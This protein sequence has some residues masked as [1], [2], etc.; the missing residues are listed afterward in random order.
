MPNATISLPQT[1][2]LASL[3]KFVLELDYYSEHN[4]LIIEM[5]KEDAFYSPFAMLILASKI[6]YLKDK[7]PKLVVVFDGWERFGYLSHMG[8]FDMCGYNHGNHMGQAPANSR[9]MPITKLTS[10][11]LEESPRDRFEEMQDL[12]QRAANKIAIIL[13]QDPEERSDLFN[14]LSY[15]LR[16]IFR[17]PFE[18]G[19]TDSLFY[20]AQYWP[21]SNKVE[22][23]VADFGIGIRQGLGRNPNFRFKDDKSALECAL[24]PSVSGRTHEP[25]YS[26]TWFNSGYGLY[27]I[28][29]LARNGGN[30]AIVSGD[31]SICMT[32]K[33]KYNY[34]TSFPG[35][36]IRVNLNVAKIGDIQ[37][38]LSEFREE[39]K[40]L[41][42]KISGSGNRPPSAMSMLLRRDYSHGRR[43][44]Q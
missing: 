29:R 9:Y 39:G 44:T 1:T 2:D 14:I 10:G 24:L 31:A 33:E 32:P 13:A 43:K 30:F 23:S 25:R 5:P 17:N 18:H 27:M 4:R 19:D 37:K 15:S 26:P 35:T 6:K 21:K 28:N 22:F 8:F 11:D 16:E 3:L 7:C 36:I 38:R 40:E 41:A 42:A 12:I 20:C 34:L